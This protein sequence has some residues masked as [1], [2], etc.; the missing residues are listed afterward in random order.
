MVNSI[1][2]I[3][4]EFFFFLTTPEGVLF[5]AALEFIIFLLVT[6]MTISEYIR[7]R[8]SEHKYLFLAFASLALQRFLT[9]F[10]Y[11]NTVFGELNLSRLS[12]FLPATLQTLEAFAFILLANA[13]IYPYRLNRKK[14]VSSIEL[15]TVS[16]FAVAGIIELIWLRSSAVNKYL[17]FTS[18]YGFFLFSIIK[19][20]ILCYPIYRIMRYKDIVR[21]RNN[22]VIAFLVYA[23]VPF[24]HA[25]SFLW[26]G[27][28]NPRV[29][30]LTNPFPFVSV[31]LF[32]KIVYLKLVD[33]AM[34]K[35]K[36]RQSEEKYKEAKEIS[37]IKDSFVSVVSHEL[38]TPLTS[39]KLYANLLSAGKFG[40][41]ND[42]QK[43][44]IGI[45]NQETDR[46]SDLIEDIL[47]L[48]KLESK[49]E[50]LRLSKFNFYDFA[51]NNAIYELAREKGIRIKEN[52]PKKYTI[53]VDAEKFKQVFINLV[54]N[55]IKF[56]DKNGVITISAK[57][58]NEKDY[59]SIKDTG[60][61]ISP[62]N[63][64]RLFDKFFQVENYMTRDKGGT[65]LGLAIAKKIIDLHHGNIKVES[66]I[67]KGSV[68]VVEIPKDIGMF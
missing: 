29:E 32:T 54:G 68:F 57:S 63:I 16:L 33:K 4:H 34:L 61:G 44:T 30:V 22:I 51:K 10:V 35:D 11:A 36:L 42:R 56:T 59:V 47:H 49:K 17:S 8:N 26:Y 46:L 12:F 50:Q 45:I 2:G 27:D 53:K 24:I 65:G 52:V 3:F 6:Y 15:E 21:H 1:I 31:L 18:F 62:E 41:V 48:S 14:I 38:R 25:I 64:P 60:K 39:L 55:A 28:L 9:I 23:S 40:K 13:F 7:E 58:D 5:R 43:K 37:E 67:G 19:T 20:A 66:E